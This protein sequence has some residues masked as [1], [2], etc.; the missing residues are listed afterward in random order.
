MR[1]LEVRVKVKKSERVKENKIRGKGGQILVVV[2]LV[3]V[4]ILAIG[5]S[6]AS[7]NLTNLKGSTQA[8]QSQRAFTAA[9]GGV[10]S[11][12]SKLNDV[13]QFINQTSTNTGSGTVSGC[14]K[15]LGAGDKTQANCGLG[16]TPVGVDSS[17]SN[18][19][20]VVK[21]SSAYERVIQPG[22][23]AQVNLKNMALN[24]VFEVKWSKI[25][26]PN[27]QSPNSATLEFT[28]IYNNAGTYGQ[29]REAVTIDPISSQ[30]G[31][32][33]C[34]GSTTTFITKLDSTDTQWKC[35]VD[36][37][38][39]SANFEMVRIKPF[40][41]GTTV[42]VSSVSGT[43]LPVQ[44]Y[45]ITST[46]TTDSGLSRKVQVSRDALPQLP[47]IFDYVLYSGGDIIK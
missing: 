32:R 17:L 41:N 42:N 24:S 34:G 37:K 10:E 47:A 44:T 13:A 40:W 8:E 39:P 20:V 3:V 4:V 36:F 35:V 30:S 15:P 6:V 29:Q 25:A 27:E 45:D 22:D 5:L 43:A 38:L 9:E 21:A 18:S 26:N 11:T 33:Q 46:A 28:F 23:I 19:N 12:L 14:T 31:F 7:R 16:N 1:K 2:L